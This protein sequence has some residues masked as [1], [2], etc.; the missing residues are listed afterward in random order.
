MSSP[1]PRLICAVLLL[2]V[3]ASFLAPSQERRLK[4]GDLKGLASA[5]GEYGEA[6]AAKKDVIEAEAGVKEAIDKLKK[7]LK[8]RTV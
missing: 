8:M 4:D 2:P 3:L 5:L 1:T 7:K 6:Q